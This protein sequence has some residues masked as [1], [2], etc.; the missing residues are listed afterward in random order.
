MKPPRLVYICCDS[1]ALPVVQ[2]QVVGMLQRQAERGYVYDLA[3]F[4]NLK[5]GLLSHV[6]NKAFMGSICERLTEAR[7]RM[8]YLPSFGQCSLD[9]A[10]RRLEAWLRKELVG[11]DPVVFHCRSEYAVQIVKSL[12]RKY[13][14]T[15]LIADIRGERLSEH[16]YRMECGASLLERFMA[17]GKRRRFARWQKECLEVADRIYCISEPLRAYF[18]KLCGEGDAQVELLRTGADARLFSFDEQMRRSMRE[19]LSLEGCKVFIYSGSLVPYQK[20]E[21]MLDMFAAFRQ[22][23]AD[24]R[25]IFLTADVERARVL[26]QNAG[27]S[28]SNCVVKS[29]AVDEVTQY[30]NAADAAFL[31]REDIALNHFASPTKLAEYWM[32]GLPVITGPGL[33][34][35]LATIHENP[36]MGMVVDLDAPESWPGVYRKIVEMDIMAVD[37]SAIRVKA[38]EGYSREGFFREMDHCLADMAEP[39]C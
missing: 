35:A 17:G 4:G 37:R 38:L 33:P 6:E 21:L 30:L 36:E 39:G 32:T 31:L 8:W 20:V 27:I 3:L 11:G 24:A 10:S 29:V 22:C 5:T 26:V 15:R 2:A 18:S 25:L 13:P 7:V 16:T 14:A 12:R 34:D 9:F 28:E 19:R 1:P 23:D